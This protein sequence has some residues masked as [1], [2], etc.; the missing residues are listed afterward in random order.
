MT[1]AICPDRS[2]CT[3]VE[4]TTIWVVADT[5]DVA[6]T[7]PVCKCGHSRGS[8]LHYRKGTDCG[9]CQNGECT[10]FRR[11]TPRVAVLSSLL[12]S[13]TRVLRQD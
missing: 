2:T 3:P 8:H 12:K 1:A 11:S 7:E 6:R 10:R 9:V 4:T 13:I 5:E